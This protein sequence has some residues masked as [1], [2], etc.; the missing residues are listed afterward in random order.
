[1]STNLTNPATEGRFRA[2][3]I[4]LSLAVPA[5][6]SFLI[7]QPQT[8]KL[9]AIDVSVLP[10]FHALL[11]SLTAVALITGYYFIKNGNRG[12]HRLAMLTAFVLS[13][14]FLVSYVVYHY[15]AAPTK[16]GGEGVLKGIYYFILLTHI[17]LAAA[18]V[19]LVLFSVYFGL[20]NQLS[21][22]KRVSKWTFPLWLYVAITGVLVY[23]MISPYYS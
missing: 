1:M 15:Q 23:W 12:A 5:L 18:I 6:V 22:H 8:G 21:R 4:V 17:V 2:L 14:I 16:F 3:I 13:S 9:G 7:L 10:K 19:P 11:N 20:T